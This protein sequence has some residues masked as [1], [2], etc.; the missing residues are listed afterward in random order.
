MVGQ[1]KDRSEACIRTPSSPLQD[2]IEFT[3]VGF[4]EKD[5][6]TVIPSAGDMIKRAFMLLFLMPLPPK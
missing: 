5:P 3:V 2:R 6:L 4:S 1:L